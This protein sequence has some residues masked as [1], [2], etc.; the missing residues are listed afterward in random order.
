[1]DKLLE[2][3][4]FVKLSHKAFFYT[5]GKALFKIRESRLYRNYW[6]NWNDY[7][8]EQFGWKR[9]Y[10][11]RLI[12]ATQVVDNLIEHLGINFPLPTSE[13]Q[14]RKL[15]GFSCLE[16]AR[17]WKEAVEK[18][19]GKI[20]TGRMIAEIIAGFDEVQ[21]VEGKVVGTV[22]TINIDEFNVFTL[23]SVPVKDKLLLPKEPAVYFAIS[24]KQGIQYI[25]QTC[26]LKRRWKNHDLLFELLD[27]Q[28]FYLIYYGEER[29]RVLLE[30]AFI[31]KY[32]P[33]KNKCRN[34]EHFAELQ[35][36]AQGNL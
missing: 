35:L 28:I 18:N 22:A 6:R 11:N 23:P 9:S 34:N 29:S 31:T 14:V 19:S 12:A 1:M 4:E 30:S 17:I 5:S 2:L 32:M 3:T 24:L 20:P 7:V 8:S 15:I 10:A 36:Q 13:Q 33:P 16:Q 25:G 27:C 21:L 26:N